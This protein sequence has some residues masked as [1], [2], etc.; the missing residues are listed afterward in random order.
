MGLTTPLGCAGCI[1][2]A[3]FVL[4]RPS[5]DTPSVCALPSSMV[6]A[7]IL[8]GKLPAGGEKEMMGM[9]DMMGRCMDAMSSMMG[10]GMMGSGI[11]P[12]VLLLVLLL[13][14]AGLAAVGGLGFWALKKLR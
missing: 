9:N 12:V 5:E 13:W 1:L 8:W 14:L 6:G 2:W 7:A 11:V 10:G 4:S 3:F